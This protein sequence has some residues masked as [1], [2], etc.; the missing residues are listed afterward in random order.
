MYPI[1][2]GPRNIPAILYVTIIEIATPGEYFFECAPS[3]NTIGTTAAVPKP[4]RQKPAS[5]NQKVGIKIATKTPREIR[6]AL[7]TKVFGLPKFSTKES[8]ANLDNA[9]KIM[10]VR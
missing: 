9:M 1:I 6:I 5:E 3:E 7:T 4:V 2:T 8:D 10:K